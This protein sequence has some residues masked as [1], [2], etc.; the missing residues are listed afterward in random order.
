MNSLLVKGDVSGCMLLG[1]M[2]NA[3]RVTAGGLE[4]KQAAGSGIYLAYLNENSVR[5][6]AFRTA[7]GLSPEIITARGSVNKQWL[8]DGG[9]IIEATTGHKERVF[10]LMQVITPYLIAGRSLFGSPIDKVSAKAPASIDILV[11]ANLL[12]PQM[13]GLQLEMVNIPAGKFKM[14]STEE[15]DE[16]PV[17]DVGLSAF[18]I[19]EHPVTNDQYAIYIGQTGYKSPAYWENVNLGI[20]EPNNPVVGVNWDDA[21]AFLE[22]L[23]MRLPTEAE[24]EYAA[25]GTE[26]LKYPWGNEW[27][28]SKA[29]FY[30]NAT[31]PVNA[32][33]EGASPFGVMDMAGNVWEWVLGWYA[34]EYNSKDLIN[35]KGPVTGTYRVLRGGSWYNNDPDRLRSALRCNL[36]PEIRGCSIG[37]RAAEGSK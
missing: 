26:S 25:R 23:E 18:R 1:A 20:A 22:W 14:G 6:K 24:W 29:T 3:Q 36:Y 28:A 11:I 34:D 5:L 27:A 35:P 21:A 17:R 37:F 33:P 32:H 15:G 13:P 2:V 9:K 19:G 4:V 10:L 7:T 30:T 16:Q 31:A 8:E 12:E